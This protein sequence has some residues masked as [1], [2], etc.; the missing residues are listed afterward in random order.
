M[1]K[2]F[3]KTSRDIE[4]IFD[5]YYPNSFSVLFPSARAGLSAILSAH[6]S[7]KNYVWIPPFA[8]HCIISSVGL[9]TTPTPVMSNQVDAT[10]VFHQWGYVH[11]P[12]T[13]GLIIEDSADTLIEPNGQVFPND[14]RYELLSLPK[15]FGSMFGGIVL[16]QYRE[17]AKVLRRIRE[18]R[19]TLKWQHFINKLR[20][21]HSK[22][23]LI[24]WH[25]AEPENGFLPAIV[26]EDIYRKI[27]Y[28]DDMANNRKTVLDKVKNLKLNTYGKISETRLPT[29]LALD[30][31][32][33]KK[34]SINLNPYERH[35][36]LDQ[37][38]KFMTRVLPLAVHKDCTQ[39]KFENFVKK[40]TLG[41]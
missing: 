31:D 35:F 4:D 40:L 34:D 18:Q 17:D 9:S 6:L 32:K 26:C 21:N 33:I 28:L 12:E 29:C 19:T 30:L 39:N 7:R 24:N 13:R 20:S 14:G 8:S 23:S 22:V 41:R 38:F 5:G 25:H 36:S 27:N 37:D 15:I 2:P 1:L 3:G 16:C 10:L 11:K